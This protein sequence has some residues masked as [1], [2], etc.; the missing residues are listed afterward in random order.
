MEA[1][2]KSAKR[3]TEIISMRLSEEDKRMLDQV[4]AMAPL[5]PRLTLARFAMRIG[6]KKIKGQRGALLAISR[7]E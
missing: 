3:L 7:L 4:A 2:N 1:R 5:V 6:L